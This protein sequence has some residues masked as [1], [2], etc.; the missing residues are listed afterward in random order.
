MAVKSK[1]WPNALLFLLTVLSTYLVGL[2]W[3][4]NY[5][6]PEQLSA[7]GARFNWHSLF[8]D[9]KVMLLGV[10]YAVVLMTI[11][12]GHELGHYLTC[13]RYGLSA[14]LP[15]FIP[16][17]T[18]VGTLGAFIKIKSPIAGKRSLFDIGM[19]GPLVGFALSVPAVIAGLLLAKTI[20]LIP[21]DDT[22]AFGEPLLM[23]IV[24]G[25]FMKVPA[26]YDLVL[27]PIGFA[28]WVGLLVSS[29]NLFPVGQLDGG[30][31]AYA[32]LGRRSR[33]LSVAIIPVFVMMGI[34]FWFGW[35]LWALVIM[36]LGLRHPI[37]LDEASDIGTARKIIGIV[38]IAVFILSFIPDPVRGYDLLSVLRQVGIGLK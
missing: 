38:C 31:I 27:H 29:F 37:V 5:L 13:R 35:L 30:H 24:G 8:V 2:S 14:T 3:G 15:Y 21:H 19:A 9:R 6:Y 32:I 33:I 22:I 1:T 4:A 7:E 16:A 34:F 23:K 17:P 36:L 26:G 11:L 10:L 20:P 18:L 28:G 12:L 25:L